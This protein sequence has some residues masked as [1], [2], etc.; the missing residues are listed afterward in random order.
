M[1]SYAIAQAVHL[2]GAI[3]VVGAG[4]MFG[5]AR[6]KEAMQGQTEIY[7][8][9]YWT[10]VDEILNALLFLLLG[11]EMITV[12]F[13]AHQS[14]LLLGAIPL[15]LIARFAVVLPWG[16]YYRIR[17]SEKRPTLILGWGGLH[18]AL[19]LAL[20]LTIPQVPERAL[21]LSITY[22]VVAFSIMVQG[23]TFTPLVRWIE[24][25]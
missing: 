24:R 11:V 5:G 15:V 16:A 6:A 17:H 18:G 7:L 25:R 21:I 20:A 2:S 19:S 3:A 14:G 10:L 9:G 12:P 4:M 1:A 13:Y 23:L 22:A 8:M